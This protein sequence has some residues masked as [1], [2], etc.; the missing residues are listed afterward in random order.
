[1]AVEVT[2]HGYYTPEFDIP[3]IPYPKVAAD[4]A[5]TR[6]ACGRAWIEVDCAPNRDAILRAI[7]RGEH[8]NGFVARGTGLAA[9]G[10]QRWTSS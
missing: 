8:E 3:A 6:E 9:G 4:D 10:Q 7:R 1:D 2:S 5:H